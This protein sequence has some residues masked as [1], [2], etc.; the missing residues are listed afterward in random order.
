MLFVDDGQCEVVELHRILK[1]GVC[2]DGDLNLARGDGGG[3]LA[4]DSEDI[5]ACSSIGPSF[6]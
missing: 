4:F 6:S 1:Q 5:P 3:L 2:T